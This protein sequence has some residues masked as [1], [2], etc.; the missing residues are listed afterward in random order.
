MDEAELMRACCDLTRV[1]RAWEGC[2]HP[3]PGQSETVSSGRL[4]AAQIVRHKPGKRCLIKYRGVSLR[5]NSFE[6]LGKVRFKG[7]D[8]RSAEV[9]RKLFESGFDDNQA[10]CVPRVLGQVPALNM[11]LQQAV[12]DA[13]PL[14]VDSPGFVGAQA[15]VATGL[16]KLHGSTLIT[17][18]PFTLQDE[19]SLLEA[20][21]EA[22]AETDPAMARWITPLRRGVQAIALNIDTALPQVLI[23]RDFY[24]EQVLISPR[25][26]WLIDF[27]CCCVG[28]PELDVGNYVAHLRELAVRYPLSANCYHEAEECFLHAY[29]GECYS[30]RREQMQWWCGLSLARHVILSRLIPGRRH[31]TQSLCEQV[32]SLAKT[33]A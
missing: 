6:V 27:D 8:S 26:T 29:Y 21:Y 24:F 17:A 18:R 13:T 9:Q 30:K 15:K 5:G 28:P 4:L 31:T 23:H 7:I 10:T 14:D 20:R 11:W 33:R 25:Q 1:T 22:L 19:L 3:L 16:A 2:T 12:V 32:L